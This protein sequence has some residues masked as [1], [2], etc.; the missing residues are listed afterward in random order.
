MGSFDDEMTLMPPS[1]EELNSKIGGAYSIVSLI[2]FDGR[3]A[4]YEATRVGVGNRVVIKLLP[5]AKKAS[6]VDPNDVF[7]RGAQILA[8]L[9]HENIFAVYDSGLTE[10]GLPFLCTEPAN[11]TDLAG[12]LQNRRIDP[13]QAVQWSLQICQGLHYLH[14][15]GVLHLEAS[16]E[17]I[18]ITP[19]GVVKIADFGLTEIYM[20]GGLSRSGLEMATANY[21]APECFENADQVDRRADVYSVGVL[22]YQMLTGS[23][24]GEGW[25]SVARVTPGVDERMEEILAGC[26]GSNPEHRFSTT[27]FVAKLLGRIMAEPVPAA[28][29]PAESPP[30]APRSVFPWILVSTSMGMI[31]ASILAGVLFVSSAGKERK[32]KGEISKVIE[33]KNQAEENLRELRKQKMLD[34]STKLRRDANSETISETISEL[35]QKIRELESALK[36]VESASE[37][38]KEELERVQ[39]E[40]EEYQEKY[41]VSVRA[42]APGTEIGQ[43]NTMDGTVYE[44]VV[45]QSISESKID[46]RHAFGSVSEDFENLQQPIRDK[47]AYSP[48]RAAEERKRE[49]ERQQ[50]IEE[51]RRKEE[52]RKRAFLAQR[53]EQ[54]K[55]QEKES[56]RWRLEGINDQIARKEEEIERCAGIIERIQNDEGGIRI[57]QIDKNRTMRPFR[58]RIGRMQAD[59]RNLKKDAELLQGVLVK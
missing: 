42:A 38:S 45:I 22:L 49:M 20:A 9:R 23:L 31:T 41:R 2:G 53:E 55:R 50:E 30:P 12:L 1:P 58:E 27:A 47:Y 33:Q 5:P 3:G 43:L 14:E 39:R 6:G 24:P 28:S 54:K 25:Q 11:G 44:K 16:P 52:A 15:N 37:S 29:E 48:V 56:A 32:W 19:E 51:E 13:D 46:F 34:D 4:L 26:L 10:D 59:I 40:F 35:E 8:Q 17:N 57:S 7:E 21:V 36:K 18:F